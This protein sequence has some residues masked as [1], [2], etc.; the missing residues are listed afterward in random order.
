MISLTFYL[1]TFALVINPH[2][3]KWFISVTEIEDPTYICYMI[4]NDTWA[5]INRYELNDFDPEDS[6]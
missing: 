2:F 6:Y 5:C 1:F 4:K 3:G